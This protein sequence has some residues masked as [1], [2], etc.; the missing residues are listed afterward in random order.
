MKRFTA[1][2]VIGVCMGFGIAAVFRPETKVPDMPELSQDDLIKPTA[3]KSSELSPDLKPKTMEKL[4]S[5][6]GNLVLEVAS[7]QDTPADPKPEDPTTVA[8]VLNI[9]ISEQQILRMEQELPELQ[10][11]VSL[12]RDNK[13]WTVRFHRQDNLLSLTGIN[14]NDLI[15]FEQIERIKKDPS[16][17]QLISRLENIMLQLQR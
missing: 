9:D 14:D 10:K 17:T 2:L 11:D 1:G 12:Y 5:K 4:A 7:A 16:K 6:K 3:I 15:R 13:G 8:N